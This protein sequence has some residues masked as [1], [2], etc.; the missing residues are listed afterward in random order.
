MYFEFLR[1]EFKDVNGLLLT[2]KLADVDCHEKYL[3]IFCPFSVLVE[4]LFG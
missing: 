2:M 3:S 4:E 1:F